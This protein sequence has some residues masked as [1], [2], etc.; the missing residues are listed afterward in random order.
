MLRY[1][2]LETWSSSS[3]IPA[4]NFFCLG[5]GGG[6]AENSWQDETRDALL[7]KGY[8]AEAFLRRSKFLVG[9]SRILHGPFRV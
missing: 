2:V 9:L 8:E 5:V 7:E 4:E 6:T 3:C 1:V